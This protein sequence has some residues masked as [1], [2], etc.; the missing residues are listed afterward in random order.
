MTWRKR[1]FFVSRDVVFS[2]GIFPFEE[3]FKFDTGELPTVV[4]MDEAFAESPTPVLRGVPRRV[5]RTL[6]SHR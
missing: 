2:E 4:A 5:P 6:L 1:F 3:N